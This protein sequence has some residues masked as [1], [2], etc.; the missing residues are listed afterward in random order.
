MTSNEPAS[1]NKS[2]HQELPKKEPAKKV[3]FLAVMGSVFA[4]M[5]GVRANKYRERDFQHGK[6]WHFILGGVI[7]TILFIVVLVVLVQLI[8]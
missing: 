4:A 6:P 8:L 1:E 7:A 3:G 2:G 5:F